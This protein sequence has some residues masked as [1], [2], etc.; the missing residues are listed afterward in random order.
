MLSKT[1]TTSILLTLALTGCIPDA[2]QDD[3]F[4][5]YLSR[6]SNVLEVDTVATPK[7]ITLKIADK[8]SLRKEMPRV[9]MGLLESYGFRQCGLFNVIAEKNSSLG[10]VQDQF[11]NFDYQVTL[12][13]TLDMCMNSTE[14]S[15]KE[16][17]TLVELKT[18]KTEHL[19]H[20]WHN[21]ITQSDE[22]RK[23][24]S[25]T[26]WLTDEDYNLVASLEPG[27]KALSLG[28]NYSDFQ[29][30]LPV[31]P[32]QQNIDKTR[33]IGPLLYSLKR[34]SLWLNS[35]TDML[36]KNSRRIVCV[37]HHSR[38]RLEYTTNVFNL[39]FVGEIQPY[40]S[41]LDQIYSELGPYI[42][43]LVAPYGPPLD[44]TYS[45]AHKEFR[46]A[47]LDHVDFW[48]VTFQRCGKSL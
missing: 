35:T 39:F 10:K 16:R 28:G 40:L 21:L 7:K 41:K 38:K 27:L 20:H 12:L 47:V 1:V 46:K 3:M 4:E 5:N 43:E 2:E 33:I 31:V 42:D 37:K 9:S 8:R 23:Q 14:L 25:K 18:V 34:S 17:N 36:W 6:L 30:L 26:R 45:N 24:L 44:T 15:E 13:K 22:V 11:A 48:N 19:P 32:H 29:N